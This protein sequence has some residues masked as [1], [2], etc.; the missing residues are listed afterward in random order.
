MT[1]SLHPV[2]FPLPTLLRS[3]SPSSVYIP[4]PDVFFSPFD[5]SFN[6]LLPLPPKILCRSRLVHH[7]PTFFYRNFTGEFFSV[8]SLKVDEVFLMKPTFKYTSRSVSVLAKAFL[9]RS[10]SLWEQGGHK[11]DE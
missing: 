2:P 11:S 8:R 6:R 3:S 7:R 4:R 5:W 10:E 9:G 1:L